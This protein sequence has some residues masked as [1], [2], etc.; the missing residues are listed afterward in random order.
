MSGIDTSERSGRRP[1]DLESFSSLF[2][3]SFGYGLDIALLDGA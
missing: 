2:F 3:L 1:P